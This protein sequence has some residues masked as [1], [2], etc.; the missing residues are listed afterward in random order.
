MGVAVGVHCARRKCLFADRI[1]QT[2]E[3]LWQSGGN[4]MAGA[5]HGLRT[6]GAAV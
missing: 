2:G 3:E 1:G 4:A 5:A 6:G